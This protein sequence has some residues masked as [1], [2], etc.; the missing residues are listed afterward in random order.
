M[1]KF[2][3][4]SI[5]YTF[6]VYISITLLLCTVL[7]SALVGFQ[8]SRML[9]TSLENKGKSLGSYVA[10]ISQD[11]LVMKDSIQL[12]SIVGEV[13][14]DEDILFAFISNMDGS[15]M[16]S[17]FTS[18]DYQSPLVKS[19][20]AGLP[21]GA[22]LAEVIASIRRNNS[23]TELSIPIL[24]GDVTIGNVT[25]CLSRENINRQITTTILFIVFLNIV[26]VLVLGWVLLALSKKIVFDPLTQLVAAT[27]TLAGGN[28]DTRIDITASGEIKT[29]IEAFNRMRVELNSSTVSREHAEAANQAKSQFL[30]TM[31]HEIRT[32]MNGVI[33]MTDLLLETE[34]TDDQREYAVIVKKWVMSPCC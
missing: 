17:L 8:E 21:R 30:A 10:L 25:I 28:L 1:H 34:L 16:T 14:K 33:G 23:I 22:E 20:L 26:V 15:I 32:P 9:N 6:I 18:I 5:R 31:S 7:L 27:A 24:S 13:T 2:H 12:D 3:N 4:T 29:L 19:A 11:P